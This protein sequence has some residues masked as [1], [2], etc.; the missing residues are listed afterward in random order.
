MKKIKNIFNEEAYH[1]VSESGLNTYLIHRPGFKQSSAVYATPFGALNLKQ[2]YQGLEVEHKSGLAHFLEHKLFE[3]DSIDV[4]SLFAQMGASG[5]AFTSYDHT[6]YYFNHNGPIKEPLETLLS[7]VS[8][9]DIS[10]ASVEKEKGIIVEELKMYEQMPDM[11]LLMETYRNVYH[12]YPYIY[13]I[14]GT[15]NS[16][17]ETTLADLKQAYQLNYADHRMVLVVVSGEPLENLKTIIDTATQSHDKSVLEVEDV[18]EEEL[19]SVRHEHREI[20]GDIT[21]PKMS[22]AFKFPYQ[23]ENRLKDEFLLKI[24]LEM[25]FSELNPEYQ[26]LLDSG[27]FTNAFGFDIDLKDA[28]GVIYFFNESDFF[29]RFIE[30]I[31]RMMASLPLDSVLFSQLKK[32]YYGE[33][34]FSLS[35]ISRIGI[36]FARAHFDGLN[37]YEYLEMVQALTFDDLSSV[38]QYL[39]EFSKSSLL[40]NPTE[41]A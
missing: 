14:A 34:I 10:E 12:T 38:Q 27:V 11:N 19:M 13:D 35:S 4:L 37:Y 8:K 21:T 18:F 32:R 17:N 15:E 39:S 30:A 28:F 16:V 22:Y 2:K 3:D 6:M 36:T 29:D 9:F 7:F 23:G 40:M 33:M 1:Y 31:D 5:N 26:D 25:T 24:I 20:K 41:V